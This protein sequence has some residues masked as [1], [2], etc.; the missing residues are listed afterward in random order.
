[1][2]TEGVGAVV[3]QVAPGSIWQVAEQPSWFRL[4]PSS[5]SSPATL[6]RP[7]PQ[8]LQNLP[9][10]VTRASQQSFLSAPQLVFK[11]ANSSRVQN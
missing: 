3:V 4:F 10:K 5:Q 9:G 11:D 6:M 8:M 1:M 2:Q 7:S